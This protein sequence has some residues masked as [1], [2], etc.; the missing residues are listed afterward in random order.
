MKWLEDTIPPEWETHLQLTHSL[1]RTVISCG[2]IGC[3]HLS[4]LLIEIIE[5]RMKATTTGWISQKECSKRVIC[6]E[7][8]TEVLFIVANEEM[9][10]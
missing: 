10:T 4:V 5:V 9:Q 3:Q 1:V 2:R 6:A 7:W 8:N